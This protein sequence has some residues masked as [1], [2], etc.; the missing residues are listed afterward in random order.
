MSSRR[1]SRS[2]WLDRFGNGIAFSTFNPGMLER[3][4]TIV[5]SQPGHADV[6]E[7]GID[8]PAIEGRRAQAGP[9][10]G[11]IEIGEL[12]KDSTPD[13]SGLEAVCPARPSGCRLD[14]SDGDADRARRGTDDRSLEDWQRCTGTKPAAIWGSAPSGGSGMLRSCVVTVRWAVPVAS[15]SNI[16][17]LGVGRA[18]QAQRVAQLVEHRGLEVIL[19][20]ADLGRVRA[21]VPVPA[22]DIVI[23][24]VAAL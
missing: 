8:G 23:S 17:E 2:E 7:Q 19:A 12:S 10:A 9:D 1:N 21:R 4:E 20:R 13:P 11:C 3:S 24:L 18:A 5:G 22:L 16:G 14:R 15:V 6:V